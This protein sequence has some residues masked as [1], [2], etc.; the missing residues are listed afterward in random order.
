VLVYRVRR[1]LHD[2]D[3]GPA[4]VLVD[5][6]RD[7]AVG[8]PAQAS[9]PQRDAEE[10]GNLAGQLRVR[11]AGENLQVAEPG[12]HEAFTAEWSSHSVSF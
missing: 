5:L 10:V 1:R 2:E 7:L 4:D 3:V 11:A 6:E 12:R 9:L 8:K